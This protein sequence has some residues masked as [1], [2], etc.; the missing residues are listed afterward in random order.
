MNRIGLAAGTARAAAM[1]ALLGIAAGCAPKTQPVIPHAA[2]VQ[3]E[4]ERHAIAAPDTTRVRVSYPEFVGAR[5]PTALDSLTAAVHRLVTAPIV[6]NRGATDAG[7]LAEGFIRVWADQRDRT[8][9]RAFWKWRREVEVIADTF[10]VVSLERRDEGYVGGAHGLAT[11]SLVMVDADSGRTLHFADLFR[12]DLRDSLSKALE[13]AFRAARGLS[14][15]TSLT[16]AGFT[17]PGGR[18]HV[19]DNLALVPEGVRWHFDGYE[20]APWSMGPTELTVPFAL[21]RP[22]VRADGPLGAGRRG[23]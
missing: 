16:A 9:S 5:T 17:F 19:N 22:F 21:V 18:F 8:H 12:S 23:R 4:V 15:D 14:A 11:A 6:G 7:A 3:R 1:A 20:I 2:H 13:P 10:G